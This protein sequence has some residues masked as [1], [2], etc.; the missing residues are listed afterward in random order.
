MRVPNVTQRLIRGVVIAGLVIAGAVVTAPASHADGSCVYPL[1]SETYNSSDQSVIVA[2]DWCGNAERLS[3]DAPPCG[4]SDPTKVLFPG[5]HTPSTED[6]DAFRVDAGC[7]Y[8]YQVYSVLT[9]WGDAQTV[10]RRGR[11]NQW[12]RVHDDQTAYVRTQT[13]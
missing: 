5:D 11:G 4:W 9:G 12:I 2:H 6:W 10:D 13:C 7:L 3:Q 8:A 1:C